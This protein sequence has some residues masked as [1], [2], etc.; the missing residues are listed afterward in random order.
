MQ[1]PPLEQV[2]PYRLEHMSTIVTP[3]YHLAH[4]VTPTYFTPSRLTT[5]THVGTSVYSTPYSVGPS[6]YFAYP[7]SAPF[8]YPAYAHQSVHPYPAQGYHIF[9]PGSSED[10]LPHQSARHAALHHQHN[11]GNAPYLHLPQSPSPLP[12]NALSSRPTSV[13]LPA[14]TDTVS[15]DSKR[16][17]QESNVEFDRRTLIHSRSADL[18]LHPDGV[19]LPPVPDAI[20]SHKRTASASTVSTSGPSAVSQH[21][22]RNG[23]R[24]PSDATH[25]LHQRSR[26]DWSHI[27]RGTAQ[28][29]EIRCSVTEGRR[30]VFPDSTPGSL[31]HP[32]REELSLRSGTESP[33]R[34]GIDVASTPDHRQKHNSERT[35]LAPSLR[36]LDDGTAIVQE[37]AVLRS[38]LAWL[39]Q[40]APKL[41]P[42]AKIEEEEGQDWNELGQLALTTPR[43]A[44]V[45]TVEETNSAKKRKRLEASAD[46]RDLPATVAMLP[47]SPS[48][49]RGKYSPSTDLGSSITSVEHFG[50][51][52][53]KQELALRFLGL[54]GS[55]VES[56]AKADGDEEKDSEPAKVTADRHS[57]EK[58]SPISI[59]TKSTRATNAILAHAPDWPDS[60]PPWTQ[61]V[62]WLQKRQLQQTTMLEREKTSSLERY[63]EAPSEDESSDTDSRAVLMK[64][65]KERGR[66]SKTSSDAREAVLRA[67]QK[68]KTLVE[69]DLEIGAALPIISPAEEAGCLC[70]GLNEEGGGMVCCDGCS[71]WYHLSCCG[72]ASEDELEDQWFCRRCDVEGPVSHVLDS[73]PDPIGVPVTPKLRQALG[74]TFSAT[75]ETARSY[76]AHTSDAALAP[77]PTFSPGAHFPTPLMDTPALYASPRLPSGSSVASKSVIP[78]SPRTYTKPRIV[79]YAEHYNICQ[80]PGAPDSD[81]KKIYSTPK[82]EDF[83]D[84]GVMQSGST[85]VQRN[86]GSPTPLNK[87]RIGGLGFPAFTTPTTSQ[88]FLRSLQIGATGSTPALDFLPSSASGASQSPFPISP[89]LSSAANRYKYPSVITDSISPSP[90]REHRRQVSFGARST[91]F[92]ASASHLRDSVTFE[93]VEK[94]PL[95]LGGELKALHRN[96]YAN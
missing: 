23:T 72:I 75:D 39:C 52:A 61:E 6:P 86:G 53:I 50:R 81:Y 94:G 90:Y 67:K 15:K 1:L 40:A 42:E 8:V 78:G 63:L 85:P 82:F 87:P 96:N 28:R 74:P 45:E 89:V 7:G 93:G 21:L 88:N 91:S 44:K 69:R 4:S 51:L 31:D 58:Q 41:A 19:E 84:T 57:R 47:A 43:R 33:S 54:D 95:D 60:M 2:S 18:G 16:K 30:L 3:T 65:L 13:L 12:P 77:S 76:H 46:S 32:T 49:R 11:L 14:R 5:P 56:E 36:T 71:T 68:G 35:T 59:S 55:H 48:K 80:T 38:D 66:T 73:P 37:R 70:G 22:G 34:D 92:S 26:S 9:P 62:D 83:F 20:R 64:H 79:S 25:P 24:L 29:L 17:P 10:M 27:R